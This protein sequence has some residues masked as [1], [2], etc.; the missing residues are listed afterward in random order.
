MTNRL[1]QVL[2]FAEADDSI[3]AIRSVDQ[4]IAHYK[5]ASDRAE[6]AAARQATAESRLV[7]RTQ[8]NS[9]QLRRLERWSNAA[10]Q[11][12]FTAESNLIEAIR[13]FHDSDDGSSN[14]DLS[15]QGK[16]CA[17]MRDGILY[18]VAWNAEDHIMTLTT[19]SIANFADLDAMAALAN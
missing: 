10:W 9:D 7:L 17:I 8:G 4:A 5:V 12:K 15:Q 14:F 18:V 19:L 2:A 13:L 16:P 1:E 11:V 3:D 6:A